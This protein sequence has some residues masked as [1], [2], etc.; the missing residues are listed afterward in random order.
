MPSWWQL[1]TFALFLINQSVSYLPPSN[2]YS[3]IL[4]E[5]QKE[6]TFIFISSRQLGDSGCDVVWLMPLAGD[7][8]AKM[9]QRLWVP[10]LILGP[11]S[12]LSVCACTSLLHT[13][14]CMPVFN[15]HVHPCMHLC[16]YL[17]VHSYMC[18]TWQ[19]HAEQWVSCLVSSTRQNLFQK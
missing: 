5:I 6:S 16:V 15:T 10:I 7:S 18:A 13:L 8:V 4:F 19:T 12:A 3:Q 17:W 11:Y 2:F 14:A 9:H 1:C